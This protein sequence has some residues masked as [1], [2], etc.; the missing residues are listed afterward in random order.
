MFGSW[1]LFYFIEV[2]LWCFGFLGVFSFIVLGMKVEVSSLVGR[3]MLLLDFFFGCWVGVFI[4][5]FVWVVIG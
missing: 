5:L 3:V 2:V 4:F 1:Y